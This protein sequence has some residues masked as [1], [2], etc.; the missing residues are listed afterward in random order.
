VL[1]E[2]IYKDN[3]SS[4]DLL[5]RQRELDPRHRSKQGRKDAETQSRYEDKVTRSV[6]QADNLDQ[7]KGTWPG[8]D[9]RRPR[10]TKDERREP[11][12]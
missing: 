2:I 4:D 6:Y 12:K 3:I 11:H 5:S 10:L 9:P 1:R 7:P 8:T